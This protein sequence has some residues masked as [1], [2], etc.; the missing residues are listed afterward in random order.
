MKEQ[1]PLDHSNQQLELSLKK[2]QTNPSEFWMEV[3]QWGLPVL[4]VWD[5]LAEQAK[6][7]DLVYGNETK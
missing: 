2:L 3:K 6:K 5:L 1:P 4:D 7:Q